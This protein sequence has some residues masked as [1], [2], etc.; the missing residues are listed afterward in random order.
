MHCYYWYRCFRVSWTNLRFTPC[1]LWAM[2]Y[3]HLPHALSSCYFF[4]GK[5]CVMQLELPLQAAKNPSV[6]LLRL[7]APL[8]SFPKTCIWTSLIPFYVSFGSLLLFTSKLCWCMLNQ[9]RLFM[10]K[11]SM[12]PIEHRQIQISVVNLHQWN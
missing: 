3:I 2:T 9:K 6:F 12:S 10:M 11:S 7:L 1:K 4:R 8:F 5:V